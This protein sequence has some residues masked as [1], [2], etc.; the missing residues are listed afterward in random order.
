MGRTVVEDGDGRLR[1]GWPKTHA[2]ICSV[3]ISADF[4]LSI[5]LYRTEK[6]NDFMKKQKM[7]AFCIIDESVVVILYNIPYVKVCE[8]YP[9][10]CTDLKQVS[11]NLPLNENRLSEAQLQEVVRR[12]MHAYLEYGVGAL[13]MEENNFSYQIMVPNTK[14]YLLHQEEYDAREQAVRVACDIRHAG[15]KRTRSG[16]GF[17]KGGSIEH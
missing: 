13:I 9:D 14:E 17:D 6:L 5:M 8:K 12:L 16:A 1:A 4:M 15:S 11:E 2:G 3:A 7:L 10:K